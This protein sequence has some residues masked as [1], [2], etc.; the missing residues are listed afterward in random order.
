MAR[1]IAIDN[2]SCQRM[3]VRARLGAEGH[4]VLEA[5]NEGEGLEMIRVQ[6]PNCAPLGQIMPDLER[7][8]ALNSIRESKTEIPA[9][10]VTANVWRTVSQECFQL[11]I[12]GFVNRPVERN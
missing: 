7:L 8:G 9:T 3:K 12:S 2:R 1:T 11:G 5:D 10:V 4:E 6:A